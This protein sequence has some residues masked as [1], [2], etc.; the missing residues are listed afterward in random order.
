M[1]DGRAT[2]R[3]TSQR[4]MIEMTTEAVDKGLAHTA[5]Q[6]QRRTTSLQLTWL[7][8]QLAALA[9]RWRADTWLD[10][11]LAALA[12]RCRAVTATADTAEREDALWAVVEKSRGLMGWRDRI[13][14]Q[15]MA[16]TSTD[17]IPF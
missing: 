11:Q 5:D 12:E 1:T 7:D 4:E 2:K 17:E 8:E 9:E 6:R 13:E 15:L 16:G 3:A 14:S 10:E